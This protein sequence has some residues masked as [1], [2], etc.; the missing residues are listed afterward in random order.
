LVN[1]I[2]SK[3]VRILLALLTASVLAI[4]AIAGS[5]VAQAATTLLM[6]TTYLPDPMT[7]PAYVYGATTYYIDQ[8]TLCKVQGCTT[9]P[10]VTP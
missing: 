9:K 1:T 2:K 10:V 8:T 5:V 6:G 7:N 3:T 4:S